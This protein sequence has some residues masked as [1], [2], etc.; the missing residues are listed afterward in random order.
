M[1]YPYLQLDAFLVPKNG[2]DLEIDAHRRDERRRER[3]VRIAEQEA[4]FADARVADDQ[5]LEHVVE[6]LVCG[7][8]LP[9]R[10]A[11]A[12]HLNEYGGT[13]EDIQNYPPLN[14][15]STMSTSFPDC[16]NRNAQLVDSFLFR[17]F[18]QHHR[19]P[20]LDHPRPP[21]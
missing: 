9:F 15:P 7:V 16:P 4:G 6:V 11:A 20:P 12:S 1:T 19:T 10:I 13:F 17:A 14:I 8:L 3:I 18:F 5:Q 21:L 2:L